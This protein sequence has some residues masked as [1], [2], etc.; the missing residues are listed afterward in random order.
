MGFDVRRGL[1]VERGL[2]VDLIFPNAARCY[3]GLDIS[4]SDTV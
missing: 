2:L 1:L 3:A 4:L